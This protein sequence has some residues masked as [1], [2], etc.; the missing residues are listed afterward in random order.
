MTDTAIREALERAKR[1]YTERPASARKANPSATAVLVDGL[2]CEINGPNGERAATDMPPPM[3]GTGSA[4][5]P[6]WL[7]RASIASCT[8]TTIAMRAALLGLALK[9]LEV[10][11]HSESDA[12]GL[13]GMDGVSAE[14]SP[15][16]ME[17]T[18]GADG[19]SPEQLKAL[20]EWTEDHSP[21]SCTLR[22]GVPIPLDIRVI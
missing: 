17:V 7:L 22:H 20:V 3:G 4:P 13:L 2:R 16:R 9:K 21:V 15:V 5:N 10:S 14:L 8:A 1:V 12:R 18:V 19:A 6:G 11:V